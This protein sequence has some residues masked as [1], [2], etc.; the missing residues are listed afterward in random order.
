MPARIERDYVRFAFAQCAGCTS[1]ASQFDI[2]GVVKLLF[3]V[4]NQGLQIACCKL[5]QRAAVPG[6]LRTGIAVSAGKMRHA[7]ARQDYS[8]EPERSDRARN[9]LPEG[10]AAL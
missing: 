4:A 3:V 9:C 10:I 6:E 1:P 7:T 8:L 2:A 5:F